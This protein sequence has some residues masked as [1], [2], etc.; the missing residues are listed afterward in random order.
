[1][2]S[3]AEPLSGRTRYFSHRT[4]ARLRRV[5]LRG[6][7][8]VYLGAF[9]ALPVAVIIQKGFA[10]GLRRAAERDGHARARGR[11]SG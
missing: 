6:A 5:S 4:A 11:R 3:A 7:A 10:D 8:I 2:S 9:I 1:M